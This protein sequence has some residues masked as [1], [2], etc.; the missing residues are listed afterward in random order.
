[1][2]A[3]FV[4]YSHHDRDRVVDIVESLKRSRVAVWWDDDL[5]P[6]RTWDDQVEAALE[7]ASTVIVVWSR[8]AIASENVKDEAHYAREENKALPVRLEDVEPPLRFRRLQF[9]DLFRSP[10]EA[11][12]GWN[13]LV[14]AVSERLG[15]APSSAAQGGAEV[16]PRARGG[17]AIPWR[18]VLPAALVALS[19]VTNV[20]G[21]IFFGGQN[22]AATAVSWGFG[23]AAVALAISNLV[24]VKGAK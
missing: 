16:A 24:S 2:S 4:S 9:V 3:V 20:A 22:V 17:I 13:D 11:N 10:A 12:E 14:A 15:R 8:G 6:G 21:T 23:G 1:V 18:T 19:L 7:G 5:P